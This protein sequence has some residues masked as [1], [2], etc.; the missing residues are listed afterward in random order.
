MA[1]LWQIFVAHCFHLT[2]RPAA[3]AV[4]FLAVWAIY[5]GDRLLDVRQPPVPGE[6]PRHRF[7]RRH[8]RLALALLVVAIVTAGTLCLWQLRPAVLHAGWFALAGVLAY[9]TLVHLSNVRWFKEPAAAVL[10]A[11]GT[12][13]APWAVCPDPVRILLIPWLVFAVLCL[14]NLVAIDHWESAPRRWRWLPVGAAI[15]PVVAGTAYF[16]AVAA[17]AAAIGGLCLAERHLSLS[18]RRVLVDA[19]LLTP[20][21]F[22]WL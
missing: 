17:S 7:Y 6:S 9:L 2:L 20:C 15:L 21:V 16:Q 1:V 5:L 12:F 18:A 11:A 14:A 4:L 13:A 3:H 19:V 22:L 8:G 10:F